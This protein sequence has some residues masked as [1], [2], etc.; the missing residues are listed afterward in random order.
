MGQ[1]GAV[2]RAIH[3]HYEV[4]EGDYDAKPSVFLLE[5]KNILSYPAAQ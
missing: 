4:R 3:L 5:P 2:A 1:S